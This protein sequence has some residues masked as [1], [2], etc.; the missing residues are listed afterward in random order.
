VG[1]HGR[2]ARPG[3]DRAV[4]APGGQGCSKDERRELPRHERIL[5]A[6]P[7]GRALLRGRRYRALTATTARTAPS[8]SWQRRHLSSFLTGSTN[9]RPP[10]W[11]STKALGLPTASASA[12]NAGGTGRAWVSWNRRP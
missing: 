3:D 5:H 9:T 7:R 11:G 4:M 12:T 2:R 6:L 8:S 10:A 1:R